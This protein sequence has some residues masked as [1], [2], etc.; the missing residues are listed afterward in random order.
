MGIEDDIKKIVIARLET[1]SPNKKISIGNSGEF[2]R[3]Q[4]IDSVKKENEVGLKL[5][6][7][8]IEFLK[9]FKKGILQ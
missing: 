1:L 4:L 2:T 9:S 7:I 3:D 8:E 5:I 6:Q